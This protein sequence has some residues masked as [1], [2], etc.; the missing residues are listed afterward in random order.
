MFASGQAEIQNVKPPV[1]LKWDEA[2]ASPTPHLP[3]NLFSE[4][5]F[6]RLGIGEF[7]KFNTPRLGGA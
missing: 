4:S 5:C 1:Y 3:Y 7:L 6:R 2:N